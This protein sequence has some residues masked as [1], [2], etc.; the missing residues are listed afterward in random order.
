LPGLPGVLQVKRWLLRILLA[1]G[2]GATVL[3]A[4]LWFTLF[5]PWGYT[6]PPDQ[7]PI[8]QKQTQQV[9][10]YG[11]LRQPVVRWLVIGRLPD[12]QP[13]ALPGFRKQGRNVL[14]QPGAQT[15]GEVFAVSADELRRLDR[16]ERLGLRYQRRRLPLASG[17]MAWVYQRLD[18]A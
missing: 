6:P 2:T 9:F 10:A 11:T 13:A 4:W 17:S 12:V 18:D 8:A 5:S 14:P 16:Y 3:L 7:P 1:V 15:R